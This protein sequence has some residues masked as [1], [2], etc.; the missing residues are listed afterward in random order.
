MVISSL[1]Y[2]PVTKMIVSVWICDQKRCATGEWYPLPSPTF[3]LQQMFSPSKFVSEEDLLDSLAGQSGQCEPCA[4][5]SSGRV[6]DG[7]CPAAFSDRLC[8][9]LQ[10][11]RLRASPSLDC[12]SEVWPYYGTAAMLMILCFTVGVPVVYYE[13]VQPPTATTPLPASPL[14]LAA[15]PQP[16]APVP[17]RSSSTPTATRRSTSSQ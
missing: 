1:L 4:F 12:L 2:I 8:P 3:N 10:T 11:S 6:A 7:S 15:A 5:L 9:E 13:L 14:T 16:C 17:S